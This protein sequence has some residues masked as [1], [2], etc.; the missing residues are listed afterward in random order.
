MNSDESIEPKSIGYGDSDLQHDENGLKDEEHLEIAL[1]LAYARKSSVM[2][3]I[4]LSKT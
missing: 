3:E 1:L 4:P 2:N